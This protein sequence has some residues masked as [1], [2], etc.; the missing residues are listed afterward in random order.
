MQALARRDGLPIL[1][2]HACFVSISIMSVP[3]DFLQ[4]LQG[5][6][7]QPRRIAVISHDRPDGDAIGSS[8]ALGA[9]LQQAGHEVAIFNADPVPQSLRFLP[10]WERVEV[11]SSKRTEA[12]EVDLVFN[13][14]AAGADRISQH[15]R[16]SVKGSMLFN[17]DHHRGNNHFGDHNWV[18]PDSPAT[19]QMI[20]QLASAFGWRCGSEIAQALYAAIS[21]D[22]G[23]LRYPATTAE[24]YRIMATLVDAGANVGEINRLLYES[25]PLRRLYGLQEVLQTAEFFA[26]H[27][28]ACLTLTMELK[29]K[30][31]L[32]PDDTEGMLDHVRGIDSVLAAV[33]FEERAEAIRVSSRSKDSRVS[34]R[35]VCEQFGGG[36]H[37][38]AA[39]VRMQGTVE[40]AKEAFLGELVRRVGEV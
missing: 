25:F 15:V 40:E 8:L 31:G 22:T 19:G 16:D 21:T 37:D 30:L 26:D 32:T 27:R 23:G 17:I 38:L 18:D 3:S 9:L 20:A 6:L 39:G 28:V 2:Q 10:G 1:K 24:T 7:S 12:H 4:A 33:F 29:Q 14:D 13:I 35:K 5:Q 34:V 36:G 11:L